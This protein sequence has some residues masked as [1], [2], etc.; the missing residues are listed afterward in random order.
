MQSQ[1]YNLAHFNRH[2]YHVIGAQL[3]WGDTQEGGFGTHLMPAACILNMFQDLIDLDWESKPVEANHA[4]NLLL[5]YCTEF[6]AVIASKEQIWSNQPDHTLL[7]VLSDAATWQVKYSSQW[8]LNILRAWYF[9]FLCKTYCAS[10]TSG[11]VLIPRWC[12]KNFEFGWCSPVSWPSVR[13]TNF[14]YWMLDCNHGMW[15]IF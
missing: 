12:H 1:T 5:V 11:C 10:W 3:D 6:M 8:I 15:C 4:P 2:W 7:L 13:I 9:H 14:L